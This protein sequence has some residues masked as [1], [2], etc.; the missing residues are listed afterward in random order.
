MDASTENP[1]LQTSLSVNIINDSCPQPSSGAAE[2]RS[3]D[4]QPVLP[5]RNPGELSA[6][7]VRSSG[8]EGGGDAG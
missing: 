2:G 1:K 4:R 6:D 5:W 3:T 7:G 8:R